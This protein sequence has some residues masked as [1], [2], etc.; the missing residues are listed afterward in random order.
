MPESGDIRVAFIGSGGVAESLAP[1]IDATQGFSVIQVL[2]RKIDN[3]HALASMLAHADAIDNPSAL[4]PDADLYILAVSDDSLAQLAA[5]LPRNEK[6]VWAHTSGSVPVTVLEPLSP[7]FG[8]LYPLQTFSKR[9]RVD[10]SEVPL[11]VEGSDKM[12]ID[13]LNRLAGSISSRIYAADSSLRRKLH[14]AAVFGCNFTNHLWAIADDIL[15]EADLDFSV[16]GPL[17]DETL[18]KALSGHPADGQTGPARR[19]DKR[20]MDA[21][22]SE[23]TPDRAAIYEMLSRSICKRYD[24]IRSDENQGRG[25]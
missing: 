5:T 3:A 13:L 21:H 22:L 1:A 25:V 14:I 24:S 23:L 17:L 16:L 20:V 2:S 11:F 12:T 9:H 8:V 7:H 10:I 18:R 6:S 4:T 15:T 19:G